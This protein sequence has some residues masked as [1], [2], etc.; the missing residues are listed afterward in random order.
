MEEAIVRVE[1]LSHRYSVDWAIR[2]VGF[3]RR[4]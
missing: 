4:R 3:Q 2:S 1:H